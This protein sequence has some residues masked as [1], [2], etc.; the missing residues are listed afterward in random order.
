MYHTLA[1]GNPQQSGADCLPCYVHKYICAVSVY[2]YKCIGMCLCVYVCMHK[3]TRAHVGGECSMLIISVLAMKTDS[4]P[5]LHVCAVLPP[6]PWFPKES[7]QL[8]TLEISIPFSLGGW[9]GRLCI[10]CI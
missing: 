7:K 2:V 8:S 3:C 9:Y 6:Q 1:T 5:F 10:F 4:A